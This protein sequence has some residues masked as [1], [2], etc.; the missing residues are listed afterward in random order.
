MLPIKYRNNITRAE[1]DETLRGLEQ[2]LEDNPGGSHAEG[3]DTLPFNHGGTTY[4]LP[5][6]FRLFAKPGEKGA[7]RNFVAHG[8][9]LLITSNGQVHSH[10]TPQDFKLH[11]KLNKLYDRI[12]I[13]IESDA[14]PIEIR[15][16][17]FTA[18]RASSSEV[19]SLSA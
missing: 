15:T 7:R 2:R 1:R 14:I 19:P 12:L 10:W 5:I 8:H 9:A 6:R 16:E 18:D 4:Q 3:S 17:L 11:T 13:V